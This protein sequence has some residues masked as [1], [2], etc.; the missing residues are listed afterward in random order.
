MSLVQESIDFAGQTMRKMDLSNDF[1]FY[2]PL[3]FGDDMKHLIIDNLDND[4]YIELHDILT[5]QGERYCKIKR[6]PDICAAEN[7][8]YFIFSSNNDRYG[9]EDNYFL[10]VYNQL[11]DSFRIVK[12]KRSIFDLV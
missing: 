3:K 1:S 4:P 5:K 7:V 6:V 9:N 12:H 2:Y 10:L 11:T 8:Y